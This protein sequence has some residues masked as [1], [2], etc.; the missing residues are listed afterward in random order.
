[1]ALL[2]GSGLFSFAL[3]GMTVVRLRDPFLDLVL[4]VDSPRWVTWVVYP[5]AIFPIYQIAL[6]AYGALLGQF[7][8]FWEREKAVGR[9]LARTITRR[10]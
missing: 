7:S 5:I 8:F 9:W 10:S 4:P 1:M 6:L 3:A 2:R